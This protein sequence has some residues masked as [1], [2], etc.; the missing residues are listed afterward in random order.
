M[1]QRWIDNL[2]A[3]EIVE[4]DPGHPGYRVPPQA[5]AVVQQALYRRNLA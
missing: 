2:M 4:A 5:S 3:K 1:A